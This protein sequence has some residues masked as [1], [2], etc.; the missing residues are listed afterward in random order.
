[1]TPPPLYGLDI[2]T[3]TTVDGLDPEVGRVLAVAV[4]GDDGVEVVAGDDE[5]ALLARLDAALAGRPTGVLVTWN[6]A[7][8]DLPYL[9]S[10]AARL[11]VPLGLQL[12]VDPTRRSH[13]AP[14]PG[15][16]GSYRARWHAHAHLD[17]YRS[18]QADV[19]PVLRMPCSLKSVARLVGLAPVEV[20]TARVHTLTPGALGAYVASDAA[21]TRE[22]A[23]RRWPTAAAAVD[24]LAGV[25]R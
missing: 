15:H 6:G 10:R 14:L 5:A 9:A 16:A 11:G 1:M 25:L 21:C 24:A 2:E 22:L 7:R 8:F 13:H 18:Y 17:V 23:L 20:D 4:A 12:E 19:A 3:D